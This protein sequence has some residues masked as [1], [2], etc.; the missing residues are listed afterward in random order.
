MP[1]APTDKKLNR[2]L[3]K[4][5]RQCYASTPKSK[6]KAVRAWGLLDSCGQIVLVKFHKD[7]LYL[8]QGEK[9]KV[10]RVEIRPIKRRTK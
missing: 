7:N 10:V 1:I 6:V 2:K 8:H 5:W 9:D 4:L 3:K